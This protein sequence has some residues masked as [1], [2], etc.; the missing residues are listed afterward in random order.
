MPPRDNPT[1]FLF[2]SSNQFRVDSVVSRFISSYTL[3]M[4]SPR[5]LLLSI[6]FAGASGIASP[7]EATDIIRRAAQRSTL[8]QPGTKPFHLHATVAPSKPD[9]ASHQSGEIEIWW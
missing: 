2:R 7:K 3:A 4:Y 9:D 5:A 8:N 6:A 1:S